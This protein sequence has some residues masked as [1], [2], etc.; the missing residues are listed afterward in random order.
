MNLIGKILTVIICVLSIIFMTMVLGVYAT[1]KNWR[2]EVMTHAE[3][4]AANKPLG[5]K[6]QLADEKKLVQELKDKLEELTKEK[7]KEL[8][9]KTQALTKLENENKL[10][11][12]RSDNNRE[13][14]GEVRRFGA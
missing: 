10:M 1:H 7:D 12:E 9:E 11:K 8:S 13:V 6:Y 2:D 14:P 3:Q 4:A 5:L